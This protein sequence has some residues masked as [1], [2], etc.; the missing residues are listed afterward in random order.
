MSDLLINLNSEQLT[1]VT[2]P[3]EP[4]LILA[5][6]G[7]GKTRVLTTRIAWLIEQG[8]VS[9]MGILALTFTNKAA[10]ELQIRLG[11][12]LSIS[13]R[14]IWIGTFHG[15]CNRMLRTHFRDAGLPEGFQIL[16]K[17]DQLSAIK[18]MMKGVN[19]DEEKYLPK[20]LQNFINSA[21]EQGLRPNEVDVNNAFNKKLVEL[22]LRYQD[23]CLREGVVDFG[24][25]LLRCFELLK[26]NEPLRIHYQSRFR[27]IFVDEFQD[28]NKLQYA[29]LKLL[30][31][32]RGVV[33]AVGDDDQ[34]I[35]GF[36]GANVGNMSDF[37]REFC[38]QHLIKLEKNYRSHG[39]IL[40]AA[41]ALIS[42]NANRLGKNLRTDAGH[43]EP[44]RV[45]EALTDLQEASWLVDEIKLLI[46]QG[47][48]RQEIAILY[49]SNVQSRVMEH[50]L[51][52]AGIPYRVYGGLRFFERQ[53]VKHALAYLRLIQN[54]NDDTAFTRIVN[55]PT[56][57]IGLRSLELLA[58]AA[59]LYQCSMYAAI[60]YM[61]GKAST[62][63][64]AFVKMIEKMCFEIENMTL[65]DA[66]RYVI[67]SSGLIAHYQMEKEGHER[68]ENLHE[69][70]HAAMVFVAEEGYGRDE[71]ARSFVLDA[72]VTPGMSLV[73][74]VTDADDVDMTPMAGFLSHASLEAGDNQAEAGQDAVQL[75]TVHASKGLEFSTVFIAGLEEGLFPHENSTSES[76]DGLEEE[77]RLMYVAI[78]RAKAR[79]YLSFTQSR[80]LH[81]QTRFNL[82][83]RFL[84]EIPETLL[85]FIMP[86]GQ[87]VSHRFFS[88][89]GNRSDWD[90]DRFSRSKVLSHEVS[91]AMKIDQNLAERSRAADTGFK[92]G[93]SVFHAKF[94]QG[95]IIA[96]EGS[97]S[98]AR[99]QVRFYRHGMKWLA[100]AV[101]KLQAID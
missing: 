19:I 58:D 30:V 41:N 84:K 40:D 4:A 51:V 90:R 96:L 48:S 47:L 14:A 71:S 77:R 45:F 1:A 99:V 50:A 34:S 97:G 7:S 69:L 83:S 54:Q 22:Y 20:N 3:D 17:S 98:E 11:T 6:A 52:G 78:T 13:T 85:K 70:V 81:G 100:L 72:R 27:H 42:N 74:R 75:M 15:L 92:I 80:M 89:T 43:G 38:V 82:K 62:N 95:K 56:R 94:G 101:A 57:G 37:E 33:F 63:L 91:T 86:R 29:W 2:L 60:A 79:L 31:G 59:S 53:E 9:P 26:H 68:V 61:K 25:L 18:R 46:D 36:R 10:K 66:V 21:K 8:K 65:P 23:Q 73:E 32:S 88:S 93:Q 67:E 39:N 87:A 44:I 16:D 28:T 5:G 55:F 12:M 76:P 49:R 64:G 35:Y 24:E